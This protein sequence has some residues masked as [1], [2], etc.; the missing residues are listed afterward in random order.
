MLSDKYLNYT[1]SRLL[2]TLYTDILSYPQGAALI[3][4]RCSTI[5]LRIE[6]YQS[7]LI[8]SLLETK[9]EE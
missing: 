3:H 7:E 1:Q 6:I 9:Q 2:S 5:K 8:R 4:L